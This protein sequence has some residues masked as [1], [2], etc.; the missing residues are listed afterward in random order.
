MYLFILSTLLSI[1]KFFLILNLFYC[2]FIS[3]INKKRGKVAKKV[4]E[5]ILNSVIIYW[6]QMSDR[7][8]SSSERKKYSSERW[9]LLWTMVDFMNWEI[10]K[11]SWT[12]NKTRQIY[13]VQLE[14]SV[15]E[16]KNFTHNFC[17][18]DFHFK[19]LD[20]YFYSKKSEAILSSKYFAETEQT[21][22]A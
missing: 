3:F 10:S 12:I 4:L 11:S 7:S 2:F 16:K 13:F 19:L 1:Q 22:K 17:S 8:S 21:W 5:I 15:H 6:E 14:K 18:R 9:I 20:V